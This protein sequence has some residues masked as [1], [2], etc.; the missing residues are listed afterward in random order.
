MKY[1]ECKSQLIIANL[2]EGKGKCPMCNLP[3]R[4][5]LR[6]T[7]MSKAY[8]FASQGLGEKK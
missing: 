8:N 4:L 3:K 7:N 5:N 1:C 6:L 2:K